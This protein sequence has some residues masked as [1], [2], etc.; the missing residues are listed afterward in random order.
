MIACILSGLAAAQVIV[1]LAG[2]AREVV[3]VLLLFQLPVLLPLLAFL[4]RA[5]LAWVAGNIFVALVAAR[6]VHNLRHPEKEGEGG[7][8]SPVRSGF[9]EIPV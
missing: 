1:F 9:K 5:A 7:S 2:N 6:V 4:V 3:S 8:P